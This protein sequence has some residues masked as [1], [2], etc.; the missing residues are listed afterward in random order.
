LIYE[1]PDATQ[2]RFV[3]PLV[4]IAYQPLKWVNI[5]G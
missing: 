1:A 4:F 5:Y 2:K 3:L